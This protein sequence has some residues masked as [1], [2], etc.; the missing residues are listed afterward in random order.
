[1]MSSGDVCQGQS[2][3]RL[4]ELIVQE[5]FGSTAKVVFPTL[6]GSRGSLVRP[7]FIIARSVWAVRH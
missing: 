7:L 4:A 1:M 2:H 6:C 5:E 3:M